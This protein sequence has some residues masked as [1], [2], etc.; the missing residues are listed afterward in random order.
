M[1]IVC[2]VENQITHTL[3]QLLATG[4]NAQGLALMKC[5]PD[6]KSI[7]QL[8]SKYNLYDYV[9]LVSPTCIEICKDF[10][11]NV[12]SHVVFV[13][14]GDGSL[15][16]LQLYTNSKIISP[17]KHAGANALL[18]ECLNEIN[19]SDKKILILQGDDA[20]RILTNYFELN[21]IN[22][23]KLQVYT[24]EKIIPD[25]NVLKEQVINKLISGIII[26][27]SLLV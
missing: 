22:Y 9:F 1:Y 27:S 4:I 25:I 18:Q 23:D 26:T 21:H 8:Q 24:R 11:I 15:Q 14:M 3:E 16:Q 5:V 12:M 20:N 19:L 10:I 6:L 2:R 13:V 17:K 7:Q